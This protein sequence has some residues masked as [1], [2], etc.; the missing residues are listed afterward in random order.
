MNTSRQKKHITLA[1]LKGI[2]QADQQPI[3]K[4]KKTAIVKKSASAKAPEAKES[5]SVAQTN[6]EKLANLAKQAEIQKEAAQRRQQRYQDAKDFLNFLCETHPLCFNLKF[7][8]PLKVGIDKD[9]LAK[10]PDKI[11]HK[12]SLTGALKIYTLNIRYWKAII[13]QD[14]RVDLD[15]NP[16]GDVTPEQKSHANEPYQRALSSL[17]EHKR[18]LIKP[19][20]KAKKD[21]V[22]A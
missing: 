14:S 3:T 2:M 18:K 17:V 20:H 15:G 16:A 10:H 9:I 12:A 21:N 22:Q 5:S 7:R 11:T 6:P 13:T 8:K 4:A 19:N 1:E